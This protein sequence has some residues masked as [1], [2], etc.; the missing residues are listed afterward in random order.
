MEKLIGIVD[1]ANPRGA[2]DE[3]DIN[4][5]A[6]ALTEFIKKCPTP[7]TIGVQG[8]W[9]S[10]KTSIL[11]SIYH[12]LNQEGI[13]KQIW[14]NSWESSLLST[15][16]EALLRIINEIIEEMIN[17]DIDKARSEKIQSTALTIFKGALRTG[18]SLIN[19]KIGDITEEL[20]QSKGNSI[21]QLR[22]SLSTLSQ[23]VMDKPTNPYKKIIV[24]VDD[25]DRLEPK[26]AVKILE[27]LKNIFSI[28]GCVFVLAIDYQVVVKGLE[29]KFGIRTEENE[30]E[31]RAFFDKIIQLPFM[32]PMGQYNIGK[33]VST[34]LGQIGFI[35]NGEI[36]ESTIQTFIGYSIGGNPRAIKRL[37]NSLALINLF[38]SI[39][40]NRNFEEHDSN[41][42]ESSKKI[43]LF[44]LVCL[45]I[46]YPEIY[47]R[48]LSNPDF[49]NW[50]DNWAFKIT[51]QKEE[52]DTKFSKNFEL[53]KET[54]DFYEDWEQALYRICYTSPRYKNRVTEISRF[55]SIIKDDILKDSN[56]KGSNLAEIL[57][58]TAV[59]SVTSSTEPQEPSFGKRIKFEGINEKIKQ[60]KGYGLNTDGIESY[61]ILMS[62]FFEHSNTN[63]NS[64]ISLGKTGASFNDDSIK[65]R[66]EKQQLYVENPKK[67]TNGIDFSIRQSTGLIDE[68]YGYINNLVDTKISDNVLWI[69]N[70]TPEDTYQ[71]RSLQLASGL[72]EV[73]GLDKYNEL[74]AYISK[75]IIQVVEER[76]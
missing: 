15:P 3:L 75:R 51:R 41:L 34:L 48:L 38:S 45:Q 59:T 64:R 54:E 68:L 42:D 39:K 35:E 24:Y 65:G 19:S 40:K 8:E 61:R 29:H 26:E 14:I 37:V 7:L 74:L 25:L 52:E 47:S 43:L 46:A 12:D 57:S 73:L 36:D 66:G 6:K 69:W 31:F 20:L 44:A 11:N 2:S 13:Y 22:D 17:C 27:L 9:G 28:Q 32:M 70:P 1:E 23:E 62:P 5:H 56:D 33:Y 60:L 67:R 18:A 71:I 55:L 63:K 10:G 50:D 53:A 30:W 76:N 16:E 58:Q 21:K 49:E 4:L 72:C